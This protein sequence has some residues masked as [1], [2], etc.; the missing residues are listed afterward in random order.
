MTAHLSRNANDDEVS[1]AGA[2]FSKS[3]L[4][5]VIACDEAMR[6]LGC[7]PCAGA[8]SSRTLR[9]PSPR[10]GG[11]L[12]RVPQA[13]GPPRLSLPC[14]RIG[15]LRK[16]RDRTLPCRLGYRCHLLSVTRCRGGRG[17]HR[18]ACLRCLYN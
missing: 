1:A 18:P 9:R 3:R 14:H 8:S 17:I 2:A 11:T 10:E 6:T 4:T 7:E 15:P 12:A 16:R 5:S 13:A